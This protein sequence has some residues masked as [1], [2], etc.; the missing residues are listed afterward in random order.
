MPAQRAQ[1]IRLRVYYST[2]APF[3]LFVLAGAAWRDL[4][5]RGACQDIKECPINN[6]SRLSIILF[7]WLL[8][9]SFSS[10]NYPGCSDIGGHR[11]CGALI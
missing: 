4:H 2:L 5:P 3:R 10:T 9:G 8:R 1:R 7:F 6:P 11:Q